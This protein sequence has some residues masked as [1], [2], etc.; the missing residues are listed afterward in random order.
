MV[1]Y[2]DLLNLKE[3]KSAL[4]QN[5]LKAL[6]INSPVSEKLAKAI[7]DKIIEYIKLRVINNKEKEYEKFNM[8]LSY[9]INYQELLLD[10]VSLLINDK[11]IDEEDLINLIKDFIYRGTSKWE[12]ILGLM[13]CGDYLEDYEIDHIV[14]VFSKSG[15]YIFYL[16]DYI[17]NIE[18][19]E[20][21][22]FNLCKKTDGIIRVFSII[23]MDF[24]KDEE[25]KYLI[26]EGYKNKE[27]T[28]LLVNYIVENNIIWKYL[29]KDDLNFRDIKNISYIVVE[30]IKDKDIE[31]LSCIIDLIKL[32]LPYAIIEGTDIYSIYA[33]Y[34]LDTVISHKRLEFIK[35]IEFLLNIINDKLKRC[36]YL[37]REA[38]KKVQGKVNDVIEL[39]EYYKY[40]FSFEELKPYLKT[41]KDGYFI[42]YYFKKSKSI[43]EIEDCRR[44]F[45]ENPEFK[46]I[47]E[48]FNDLGRSYK[49]SKNEDF[50]RKFDLE[51]KRKNSIGS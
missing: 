24:S 37:F 48:Y 35:D 6:Y 40:K 15:E 29:K 45:I 42:Y 22:L 13:L 44:Y 8:E 51:L 28:N 19:S 7:I 38:I 30:Y 49:L 21:F 25:I 3:Y 32:Y 36:E 14:N 43:L 34:L 27:Y 50:I 47:L 41:K 46:E 39:G 23:N 4:G 20:E 2:E 33:V 17:K 16:K 18:N 10:K 1:I 12:V 31:S 5:E 11:V 9:L 26:N